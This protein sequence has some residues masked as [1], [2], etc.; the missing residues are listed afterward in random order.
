MSGQG[1]VCGEYVLHSREQLSGYEDDFSPGRPR[2][3]ASDSCMSLW[4]I[5]EAYLTGSASE[6]K[7]EYRRVG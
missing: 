2:S 6:L 3:I 1:H 7:K 4:Q 5:Q